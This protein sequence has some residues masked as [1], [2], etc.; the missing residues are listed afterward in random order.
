MCGNLGSGAG[1][2]S[3]LVHAEVIEPSA[4]SWDNC[5]PFL[6]YEAPTGGSLGL[7]LP[8]EWNETACRERSMESEHLV[9]A[10][11]S[12]SSAWPFIPTMPDCLSEGHEN[13]Y[14]QTIDYTKHCELLVN[15]P[16]WIVACQ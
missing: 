16:V 6:A 4:I 14:K 3:E 15:Q 1:G 13:Q 9:G 2:C 7:R 8:L 11:S 10:F 12:G 5:S